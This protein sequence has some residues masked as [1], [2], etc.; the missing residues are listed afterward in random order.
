MN[1]IFN[2]FFGSFQELLGDYYPIFAGVFIVA[3]AVVSLYCL[4]SAVGALF[5]SF[6]GKR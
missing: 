2:F 3:V 5:R 6:G 4:L 1:E